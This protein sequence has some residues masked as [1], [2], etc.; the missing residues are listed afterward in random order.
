MCVV[1]HHDGIVFL[2]QIAECGQRADV[3]IHGEDTVGDDELASRL[4]FNRGE[5][6][7]GVCNVLMTEDQDLCSRKASAVDNGGVIQFV[8]DDEVFFAENG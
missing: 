1:N 6:L 3:A 4:I 5:L 7:F 2:R 8:G